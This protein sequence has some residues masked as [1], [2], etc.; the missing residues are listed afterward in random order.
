[1]EAY[2]GRRR[3]WTFI[4]RRFDITTTTK[5]FTTEKRLLRLKTYRNCAPFWRGASNL[6]SFSFL[7]SVRSFIFITLH[8]LYTGYQKLQ[9]GHSKICFLHALLFLIE[10]VWEEPKEGWVEEPGGGTG[11]ALCRN[12]DFGLLLM[13]SFRL[14]CYFSQNAFF[15]KGMISK[16]FLTLFTPTYLW[17]VFFNDGVDVWAVPVLGERFSACCYNRSWYRFWTEIGLHGLDVTR[18]PKANYYYHI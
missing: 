2:F 16:C 8:G 15:R 5:V 10:W 3:T 17:T 7:W 13:L 9:G 11:Q 14:Y 4:G 6:T 1:M 18:K 12:C